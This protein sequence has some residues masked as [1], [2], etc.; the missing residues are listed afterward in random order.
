MPAS[1]L[2]PVQWALNAVEE[3]LSARA[4]LTRFREAGGHVANETWYRLTGE[5]QAMLASRE[6]IYNEPVHLI[7]TAEEIQRWTTQTAHGY[8]Q[9]VEILV[10]DR[11]T[12]EVFS[13]PFSGT[14]RTLRS[15]RSVLDEALS[16][17][18]DDNAKRYNQQILG[19]V[20]TG[21]YQAV[22]EAG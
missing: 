4:G 3:G 6:G 19:A 9:Q 22:P 17:Y 14:G 12:G 7:P 13:A 10:R 5:V 1:E 18:S 8:I 16:V 2:N 15:R 20:Y 11:E 21:T